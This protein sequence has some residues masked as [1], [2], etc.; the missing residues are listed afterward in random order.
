MNPLELGKTVGVCSREST[1]V[2]VDLKIQPQSDSLGRFTPLVLKEGG[3][4]FNN[5]PVFLP[6]GGV[7]TGGKVS[8]AS[9]LL[10]IKNE[11]RN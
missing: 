5:N 6:E 3:W 9:E 8:T 7:E 2:G 4:S 10:S 1:S 11:V